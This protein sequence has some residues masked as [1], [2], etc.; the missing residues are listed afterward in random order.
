MKMDKTTENKKTIKYISNEPVFIESDIKLTIGI[1]VSNH[2]EYIRKGMESIKALLAAVPSEL[3]VVDTVGEKNSDGSL[4]VVKE[5]TDKVFHF[6]WINDF[7]AARNIAMEHAKGEWFMYFDDDEYFDDVNEII[8]FFKSGECNKYNYALYYT[9]DYYTGKEFKKTIAGRMI[10]RT[11][12]T[13]F[14]GIIHERFNEAY[15]PVKTFNVFTHHFGYLYEKPEDEEKK[16][17]R[18]LTLLE[19]DLEVNG[20]NLWTCAHYVNQLGGTNDEKAAKKSLE[21]LEILRKKGELNG[22]LAQW[23]IL[24]NIRCMARWASIDI[25]YGIKKQLEETYELTETSE[26]VLTQIMATASY[27]QKRFREAQEEA[28]RYFALYDKLLSNEESILDR[29]N[30]D[31][32]TFFQPNAYFRTAAAGLASEAILGNVDAAYEYVKRINVGDF[33][34]LLSGD[35]FDEI[36]KAMVYTLDNIK[37]HT[38]AIEFYKK[39]YKNEFF[40][41]PELYKFLPKAARERM[42]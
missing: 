28:K 10:R 33:E 8:D 21:F 4:E 41:K 26:L 16:N 42:V 13:K 38:P 23:L 14:I 37:D 19:K 25:L 11:P 35:D 34:D 20:E 15:A 1:L 40:E 2:I 12:D 7:S 22:A 29:L 3:I 6:D 5:Y 36:R 9:G 17:R 24:V 30:F 27:V 32:D 39:F 31:F 18:N